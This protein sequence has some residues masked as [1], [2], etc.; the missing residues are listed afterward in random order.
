[1]KKT[2]NN[3]NLFNVVI[4]SAL[5][6]CA[7]VLDIKAQAVE[8]RADVNTTTVTLAE[9]IKLTVYVS[10]PSTKI[11]TP[12]MP[13]L[14]NFNIYS[15]GQSRQVNMV[16]GKVSALMQF[17]Y[18]LT[19][20]FAGKTTIGA[21]IV[22]VAG[23]TYST[24]PIDVEITRDTPSSPR[25]QAQAQQ[26]AQVTQQRQ[27]DA[28][29]EAN[30][31]NPNAKLPNFFMTAQTNTKKAYINEQI[32]LKIRFYQS[33]NTLG[34]P[35]YDKPQLKGLFSEDIA[36]RQGQENFG[37][38]TYYYTEIESALFG[39]V[40]GV[41][42]IGSASV[43]Y[44]SSE[45]IFDAF[46]V[47]F[48]GANGGQT[49][50]VESDIMFVD[51]LPL[52][53]KNKPSSFY[54]AVGTAF[55]IKASLDTFEVAAGEPITLTI[56]VK[57]TGNLAAIKDIP[58]PDLGPSFR[59]YETSSDLKNKISYG[60]I[61]GIKTYKTVIV[62]RASGA[63][64]IPKIDFSYFDIDT[65]TYKSISTQP[66]VLKVLPPT[67]EDTKTLSFASQNGEE[68]GHQIQHLTKDISYLKNLPQ[69]DFNR[70]V[71]KFADLGNKNFYALALIVL[72][73]LISLIRK[74]NI[75]LTG[76][77]KYYLKAK[78]SVQRAKKL[79]ELPEI[80][81]TYFEAKMNNQI[82]L[83]NI[84]EI[85]KSLNL[86]DLTAK[87]LTDFWNHLAMLK[88]AP[89]AGNNITDTL[90]DEKHKL[91]SLLSVLEKEIK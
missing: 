86:T 1:M 37:N 61:N 46:D 12:Q 62:P 89:T 74:G 82:G 30:G 6:V 39:L 29:L 21:F 50:K 47:F 28:Q 67:A 64:D 68:A 43:T 54:G 14:P 79:D 5:F 8:V 53:S 59:V 38:K 22:K 73:F 35:M 10:A 76:S 60:K 19:P 48:R 56:K 41:A 58:L 20:R 52:P 83:K 88:Y 16:N 2:G 15:A 31:Y 69:S 91:L 55:E 87:K 17:N 27:S 51:I 13:S 84:E 49:N 66:L 25:T 36:T 9:E 75:S 63:Y 18:I 23:Q 44:N 77:F 85:S 42:E 78:K 24:E 11:E 71:L 81:K 45:G 7:F 70:I 90:K 65:K 32:T 4:L 33:Q 80:L 3:L 40:S 57:G 34:Q 72:A 26:Q